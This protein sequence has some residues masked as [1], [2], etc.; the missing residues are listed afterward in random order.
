MRNESQNETS[1]LAAKTFVCLLDLR[2]L[3]SAHGTHYRYAVKILHRKE[4]T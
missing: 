1:L 4:W 3:N 2:K